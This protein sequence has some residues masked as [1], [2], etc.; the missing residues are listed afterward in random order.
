MLEWISGRFNEITSK[1]AR[2]ENEDGNV[3]LSVLGIG[4]GDGMLLIPD[5]L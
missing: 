5:R 4:S 1:L 3:T 2:E